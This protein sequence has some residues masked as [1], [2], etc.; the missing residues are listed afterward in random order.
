MTPQQISADLPTAPAKPG[1]NRAFRGETCQVESIAP[2]VLA[3]IL[4][5][6][7]K[8]RLDPSAYYRILKQEREERDRLV[9]LIATGLPEGEI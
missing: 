6:A 3:T 5:D 8:A 4:E 7:I 1:D 9:R 2:D